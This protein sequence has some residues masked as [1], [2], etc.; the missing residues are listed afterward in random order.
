MTKIRSATDKERVVTLASL[1]LVG[2]STRTG[3]TLF[4]FFF[5]VDLFVFIG[6]T[7]GTTLVAPIADIES[8]QVEGSLK[9]LEF[10]GIKESRHDFSLKSSLA[11]NL[12]GLASS[13]PRHDVF[14]DL[15]M[16]V[17]EK[18]M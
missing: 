18:P 4:F 5:F 10:V 15:V 12:E 6:G 14:Q 11:V 1:L 3:R 7:I 17:F 2:L 13:V 9:G 16:T 8:P